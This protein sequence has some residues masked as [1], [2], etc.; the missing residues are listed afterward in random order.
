MRCARHEPVCGAREAARSRDTS[1]PYMK[2]WKANDP[3]HEHAARAEREVVRWAR[4]HADQL[5][6]LV[7]E[8][9]WPLPTYQ[10]MLFIK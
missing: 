3:G 10:E 8:D 2:A 4:E 7:T 5:K 9:L 6:S 1:V